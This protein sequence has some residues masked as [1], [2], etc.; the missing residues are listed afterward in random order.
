MKRK[1]L[2]VIGFLI[3]ICLCSC[4]QRDTAFES[5][6]SLASP[7]QAEE[8]KISSEGSSLASSNESEKSGEEKSEPGTESSS[9][10]VS[11]KSDIDILKEAETVLMKVY[12]SMIFDFPE[13]I[14]SQNPISEEEAYYCFQIYAICQRTA[15]NKEYDNW[16]IKGDN[17]YDLYY[18]KD[19]VEAFI[20]SYFGISAERM[21]K[22]EAYVPEKKGY[23]LSV[24]SGKDT[25]VIN[26]TDSVLE[27]NISTFSFT[28][29]SLYCPGEGECKISLRK[30]KDGVTLESFE[31][32]IPRV[33]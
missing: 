21:P 9:M 33:G 13:R 32:N 2:L 11:D 6:E 16:L 24:Y 26:I 7:S 15:G 12:K 17:E 29:S 19:I 14:D 31:G 22:I 20:E 10:N 8:S 4:S 23:K 5:S 3:C 28:Y 30:D 25:S 18:S 1:M 27:G